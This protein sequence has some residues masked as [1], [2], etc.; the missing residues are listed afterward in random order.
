MTTANT[1][2]IS[3]I[4]LQW[5][6]RAQGQRRQRSRRTGNLNIRHLLS[7]PYLLGQFSAAQLDG[8][9]QILHIERGLEELY[10]RN[11]KV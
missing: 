2:M 11:H 6:V 1:V 8:M 3:R 7:P 10:A 4:L 9:L 5:P